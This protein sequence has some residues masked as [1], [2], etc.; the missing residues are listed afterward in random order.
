MAGH[1]GG[2]HGA[3]P[4]TLAGFKGYSPMKGKGREGGRQ[5]GREGGWTR[6]MF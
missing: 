1:A 2:A 3:S 5:E 4:E 6:P